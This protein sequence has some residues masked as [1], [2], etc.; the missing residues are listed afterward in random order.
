MLAFEFIDNAGCNWDD[1]NTC[2]CS[3]RISV[4]HPQSKEPERPFHDPNKEEMEQL[5]Q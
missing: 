5:T 2:E 1:A 3:K 4:T